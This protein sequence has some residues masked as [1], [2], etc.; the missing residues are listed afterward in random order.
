M[1]KIVSLLEI[2]RANINVMGRWLVQRH[3]KKRRL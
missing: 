2:G 1:E 3:T